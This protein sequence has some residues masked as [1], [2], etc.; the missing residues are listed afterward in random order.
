M[1]NKWWNKLSNKYDFVDLDQFIIMPNHIHGIIRLVGA[2]PCNRPPNYVNNRPHDCTGENVV[3]PLRITNTYNGLGQ[4]ISWFKRMSTNEYIHNVNHADW[5]PFNHKLWQRNY[6]EHIIRN[7][8]DLFRIR[9]YI[10]QN[11]SN[12]K[13]D[14]L[15]LNQT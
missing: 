11:P 1:V 8:S 12:W 6:Y 14:K 10:T 15:F 5:P 13:Q 7:Q 9:R 3:S 2:I 4:I